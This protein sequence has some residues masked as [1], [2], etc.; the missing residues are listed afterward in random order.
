ME[1]T[2]QSARGGLLWEHK[3]Q[4]QGR[5]HC[6]VLAYF[7]LNVFIV[8]PEK[9]TSL[10]TKISVKTTAKCKDTKILWFFIHQD[11]A[12]HHPPSGSPTQVLLSS[13]SQANNF[14]TNSCYLQISFG[15]FLFH[16]SRSPGAAQPLCPAPVQISFPKESRFPQREWFSSKCDAEWMAGKPELWEQHKSKSNWW[17]N[18]FSTVPGWPEKQQLWGKTLLCSSFLETEHQQ[19]TKLLT[20]EQLLMA[21]QLGH[22]CRTKRLLLSE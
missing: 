3:E 18:A 12:V 11:G 2:K 22:T 13:F 4:V 10:R 1:E 15:V 21:Q 9:Q 14:Q 5:Q 8:F 17:H 19:R 20:N 6:V 7:F 16:S